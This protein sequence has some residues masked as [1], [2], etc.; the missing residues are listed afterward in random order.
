MEAEIISCF[1][2]L[3]H[4]AQ[5]LQIHSEITLSHLFE[6]SGIDPAYAADSTRVVWTQ[7]LWTTKIILKQHVS[8]KCEHGIYN[9][10]YFNGNS[11]PIPVT[12]FWLYQYEKWYTVDE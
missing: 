8:G 7:S 11:I 2:V 10:F 6:Q 9:Q 3:F 1:L 12:I 4:V 5:T